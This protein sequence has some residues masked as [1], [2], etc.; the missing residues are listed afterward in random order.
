MGEKISSQKKSSWS[1]KAQQTETPLFQRRPFSGENQT[2]NQTENQADVDFTDKPDIQ[3][4]TSSFNFNFLNI[5]SYAP[6]GSG[7]IQPKEEETEDSLADKDTGL[8]MQPDDGKQNR[9][10]FEQIFL[11]PKLTVGA[12][13]DPYE[14]EADRV[15]DQVMNTPDAAIQAPIQRETAPAAEDLQTKPLAAAITPLVQREMA[16][17]EEEVQAKPAPNLQREEMPE[18]E[19]IQTKP[20]ASIQREAMPD[21]EEVQTKPL[22]SSIQREAMP[23]EEELQAKPLGNGTLQREVMPEEEEAVQAKGSPDAA[24]PTGSNLE[25]RL[26]SSQGGGSPL[27]DEVRSFMEPRFGADF[28]Q[29][30]VHTGSDAVQMNQDLNA[31]AFTHKQD[32]YFGNGKSPAKDALTA[33]ELTH[34]VQQVSANHLQTQTEDPHQR[35]AND[36]TGVFEG[37][38]PNSLQTKDTGIISYGKHQATLASGSLYTVLKTY[39]EFSQS[40]TAIGIA[41]YLNQVQKRDASLRDDRAFIQLLKDAANDPEM[42]RAQDFVFSEKYWKPAQKAANDAGITSAL[43]KAIF[44]DTNIQGG[45]KTILKKTKQRLK[46]TEYTEQQ[47]LQ[48]FLEERREHLRAIAQSKREHAEKERTKGNEPKAKQLETTANMLDV[49]AD[50]RVGAL[51][52][53]VNSGD[54][55]LLGNEDGKFKVNGR[56]I[57]GVQRF[58]S[59]RKVDDSSNKE[60]IQRQANSARPFS[61]GF[62]PS[63]PVYVDSLEKD[64]PYGAVQ[65]EDL[66]E[67]ETDG[68]ART[69][70]L[71]VEI[72]KSQAGSVHAT[73]NDGDKKRDGW[74]N[75]LT[76]FRGSTIDGWVS[77]KAI[78]YRKGPYN[79]KQIHG[80]PHWCGIFALWALRSAGTGVGKWIPESSIANVSGIYPV[81]HE[82]VKKG[83]IGILQEHV[84]HFIVADVS[85]DT[86]TL[87]EGNG[88][89]QSEVIG[90]RQAKS[91]KSNYAFYTAM[92]SK[93]TITKEQMRKVNSSRKAIQDKTLKRL[94]LIQ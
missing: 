85:G 45:L 83:D 62:K 46:E 10:N 84:H 74:Q 8:Q 87:V 31:Q 91:A 30:R 38:K 44:Y 52:N 18:E 34:V 43:G 49:A 89:N 2:E 11:Q 64:S 9:F 33:H 66:P 32:V 7:A 25:S 51:E 29:V 54:L 60:Y 73:K 40:D 72:A 94:G 16:P 79:H 1:P 68:Y 5:P 47:F 13:N 86:I 76:Y 22:G 28:S 81:S 77:D 15:A 6:S 26:S 92:P 3:N 93:Q 39:T 41:N 90:P 14:Q 58:P 23:E 61:G 37:G 57:T 20:I 75:L 82:L 67:E 59:S 21:E 27:P 17:E 12:P 69:R 48:V 50:K 24:L 78:Q 36:I 65:Y 53:L 70:D 35:V 71:I 4:K 56:E 63:E 42:G 80:I 88:G 19:E 55:D